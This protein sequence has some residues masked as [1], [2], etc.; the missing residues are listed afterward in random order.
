MT[1]GKDDKSLREY[2]E[3]IAG[4]E[5]GEFPADPDAQRCPSCP[6][7]FICGA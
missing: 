6:Y 1:A 3:A 2:E 5:R 7:Y 4:I